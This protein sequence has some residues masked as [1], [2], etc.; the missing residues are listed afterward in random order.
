MGVSYKKTRTIASMPSRDNGKVTDVIM[1]EKRFRVV[2]LE[3]GGRGEQVIK[4]SEYY[5]QS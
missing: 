4:R 1:P 3:F 5:A 2:R